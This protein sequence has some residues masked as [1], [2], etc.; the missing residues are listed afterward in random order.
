MCHLSKTNPLTGF[1]TGLHKEILYFCKVFSVMSQTWGG[2]FFNVGT[3]SGVHL[4]DH[5]LWSIFQSSISTHYI[6]QFFKFLQ[7]LLDLCGQLSC[8]ASNA[9]PFWLVGTPSSCFPWIVPVV[10]FWL[11]LH[12][13]YKPF[14]NLS[15]W[16]CNPELES[17]LGP[18]AFSL[19]EFEIAP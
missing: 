1:N 11:N 19:L 5:L 4:F 16:Y 10:W 9:C 12:S 14:L 17:N 2:Y 15:N 13:G 18:K 6:I 8:T 7:I 3:P